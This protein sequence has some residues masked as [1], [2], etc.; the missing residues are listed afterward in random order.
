MVNS[1]M[2]NDL[3]VWDMVQRLAIYEALVAELQAR[4]LQPKYI[5]VINKDKPFYR[6]VEPV[7]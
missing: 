2:R 4:D 6:L 7:E 3:A 1:L 5:S